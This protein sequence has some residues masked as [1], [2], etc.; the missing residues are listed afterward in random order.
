MVDFERT[1]PHKVL[2]VEQKRGTLIVTPV[3]DAVSFRETDVQRE[4]TTLHALVSDP[5]VHNLVVDLG[6]ADY[7]GSIV[8]G[9][10][11]SLGLK[12]RDDGGRIA[13]CNASD[14][15]L[16]ILRVMNL[17]NIWFNFESRK[18]ALKAMES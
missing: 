13:L 5:G 1:I 17:D 9:A 7:F 11:N 10:I 15:M 2:P 8:I 3:G 14:E 16:D 4:I 18:A 12:A 6:S